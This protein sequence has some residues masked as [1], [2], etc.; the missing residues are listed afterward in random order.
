MVNLDVKERPIV[1]A[2]DPESAETIRCVDRILD[3]TDKLRDNKSSLINKDGLLYEELFAG[4][5]KK[6]DGLYVFSEIP[7]G[8]E[9]KLTPTMAVIDI[10]RLEGEEKYI[11]AVSQNR[12]AKINDWEIEKGLIHEIQHVRQIVEGTRAST[13]EEKEVDAV[14][15]QVMFF[16]E[17]EEK[18]IYKDD[19]LQRLSSL[20]KLKAANSA[21]KGN[22]DKAEGEIYNTIVEY[23]KVLGYSFAKK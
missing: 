9:D 17:L 23:L 16:D 12:L 6:F 1:F 18:A 10:S 7:S 4:H 13:K 19:L 5:L 20:L 22:E 21:L 2:P 15:H 14:L 3:I 8:E 11:F